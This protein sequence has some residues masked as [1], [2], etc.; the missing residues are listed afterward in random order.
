MG[1]TKNIFH[2]HHT[3][4]AEMKTQTDNM[5]VQAKDNG[6]YDMDDDKGQE[7]IEDGLP[8]PYDEWENTYI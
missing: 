7:N 3:A 6:D 5:F 2:A 1:A 8:D 4:T